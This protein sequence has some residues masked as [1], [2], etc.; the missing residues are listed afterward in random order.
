MAKGEPTDKRSPPG[1]ALR[2][3]AAPWSL[4]TQATLFRRQQR[5]A[6]FG[7]YK[8]KLCN[9]VSRSRA[10]GERVGPCYGAQTRSFKG[11]IAM[12]VKT[13]KALFVPDRRLCVQSLQ[14]GSPVGA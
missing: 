12:R 5:Y 2:D 14:T 1:C 8:N 6:T 9:H 13:V 4:A 3:F 7:W 11:Q 10:R